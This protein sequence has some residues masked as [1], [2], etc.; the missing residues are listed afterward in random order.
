[1]CVVIQN[2]TDYIKEGMKQLSK[3]YFYQ[4]GQSNL[5][6]T[7][8]TQVLKLVNKLHSKGTIST[9]VALNL[10]IQK[11]CTPAFYM[12]PKIHKNT[13]P[14]PGRPILSAKDSPTEHISAFVYHFLQPFVPQIKPFAKDTTDFLKWP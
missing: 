12:L 7:H 13:L 3:T 6:S 10:K 4:P 2:T 8:N 14:P 11:P 9:E 1:M 5:C